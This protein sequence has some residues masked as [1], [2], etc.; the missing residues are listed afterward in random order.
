MSTQ[1]LVAKYTN[2]NEN[3]VEM[4]FTIQQGSLPSTLEVNKEEENLSYNEE[5]TSRGNEE[6]EKFQSAESDAQTSKELVAKEEKESTSPKSH[7]KINDEVIKT[8]SEMAPWGEMHEELKNEKMTPIP[9]TE[10]CIM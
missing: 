10:E 6:L 3:M 7:E 8:I 9:K 1:E 4:H 2:E 5:I